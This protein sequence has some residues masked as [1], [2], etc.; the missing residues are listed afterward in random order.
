M[1]DNMDG[2]IEYLLFKVTNDSISSIDVQT[3][4]FQ[5]NKADNVSTSSSGIL[6]LQDYCDIT[7]FLE[8]YVGISRS[9]T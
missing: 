2:N 4:D 3:V 6:S 9:F 1:V 5:P 7:Y 8:D